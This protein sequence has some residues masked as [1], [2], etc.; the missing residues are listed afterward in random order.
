MSES[1]VKIAEH[2][3]Q[4][5]LA[6][7]SGEQ[8]LIIVDET[9]LDI[10]KA[11][12]GAGKELGAQSSLIEI[13]PLKR[14]GAEPTPMVAQ[15]MMAADVIVAATAHS[16][17]HTQARKK[18]CAAGARMATMPGITMEMFVGGALAANY[19]EIARCTLKLA[20]LLTNAKEA[21][22]IKDGSRL[23][24]SLSGRHAVASTGIYREKGQGGNLPSGEA[25][26]AP[27]EGSAEGE[28][29]I[30]GSFSGLGTLQAPLKLTF[31]QGTLVN[32]AGPDKDRLAALLGDN[33]LA[34]NLAELGVG[35]N[36]KARVTGV[37]LED[38]K[39]YGTAHIALGSN[40]TFGGNVAAGIHL[41]GVIMAP[42]LY[43]DGKMILSKG[44]LLA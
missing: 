12:F 41:D 2:L 9:T 21:V 24:M 15:A 1:M 16:L 13:V 26:I 30:D 7:K 4:Q 39:V 35:T 25:F 37:I 36:D 22:L 33:L 29:I 17:T 8:L 10:G 38:E 27:V 31:S 23:T 34:R 18:A 43:L 42:K 6:L 5:N 28:I 44:K 40:D 3:L 19:D 20:D 32:A 11:L 14:S